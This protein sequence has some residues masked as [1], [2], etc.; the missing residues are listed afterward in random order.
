MLEDAGYQVYFLHKN[1]FQ[2]GV[3]F[4]YNQLSEVQETIVALQKLTGEPQIWIKKK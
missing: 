2:V 1:G 3:Q 4:R